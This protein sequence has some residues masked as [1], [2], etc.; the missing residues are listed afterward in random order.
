MYLEG[1]D[2]YFNINIYL[3][4]V[5]PVGIKEQLLSNKTDIYIIR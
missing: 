4:I 3:N 1:K 5:H 2:A